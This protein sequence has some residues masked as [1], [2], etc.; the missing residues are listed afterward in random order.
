MKKE[1]YATCD[2]EN[3][4]AVLVDVDGTLAHINGDNPRDPH[5]AS[6]AIEDT[7]DDAV[8][9]VTA[10]CYR[11]GYR[12]I[13]LTGRHSG[14][15]QVTKDWLAKNG[16]NYDEIYCR[17]EEDKRPDYEV[18]QELFDKHIR[19]KYNIKFVIDDRPSVCRMWRSL[20]LKVFQ[21]G[22]PHV[23]F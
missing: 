19:D 5:D 14:H 16:V 11:H 12:I 7:L 4:E 10:M 2:T 22:D 23:E 17:D 20:G 15:L 3:D 9:I 8:S 13:I 1:K 18:K 21:V 6:H